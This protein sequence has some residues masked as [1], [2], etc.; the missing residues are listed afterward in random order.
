MK[1]LIDNALS[2]EVAVLL[3]AAGHDA[4]HVRTQGLHT[5]DDAAVFKMARDEDRVLV[6]ADTDFGTMLTLGQ[7]VKP[8]VILFRHGTPRRPSEQAGL[9]V[10]NLAA[11]HDDV[12]RGAIVVFRQD[13]IRV[14]RLTKAEGDSAG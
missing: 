11:F 13:K 9:L 12:E 5:A 1:F 3:Q 10:R 6:S 8:S 2:P 7:L 14:R 4:V